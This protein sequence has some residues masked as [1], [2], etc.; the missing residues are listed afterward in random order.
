MPYTNNSL[1]YEWLS[2]LCLVYSIHS[3]R[4]PLF[5]SGAKSAPHW[6]DEDHKVLGSRDVGLRLA[7]VAEELFD[8]LVVVVLTE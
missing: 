6:S 1:A 7:R 2:S 8:L 3:R 4:L 5:I